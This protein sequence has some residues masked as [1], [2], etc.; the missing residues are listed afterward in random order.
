[1]GLVGAVVV[2]E[3]GA[4]V[5]DECD[6]GGLLATLREPC[7]WGSGFVKIYVDG[8]NGLIGGR[9]VAVFRHGGERERRCGDEKMR[10]T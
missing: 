6:L 7:S 10:W 2:V 9:G 5:M 3:D 8:T 1:M 4:E